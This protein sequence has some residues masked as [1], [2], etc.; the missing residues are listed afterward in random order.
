MDH[1]IIHFYSTVISDS[2]WSCSMASIVDKAVTINSSETITVGYFLSQVNELGSECTANFAASKPCDAT[3]FLYNAV[4]GTYDYDIAVST[5]AA[6]DNQFY[7][8]S[9]NMGGG[10]GLYTFST[11]ESYVQN[12][13]IS[14]LTS[15]SL[16][17][18]NRF[19]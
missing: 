8:S 3:E 4:P 18:F 5:L 7:F 6:N 2:T 10:G 9:G 17:L 11:G 12:T 15:F 14:I 16:L 13:I 19:I 1:F